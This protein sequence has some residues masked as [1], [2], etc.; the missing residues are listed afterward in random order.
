MKKKL[1]ARLAELKTRLEELD[2]KGD[3]ELT[4]EEVNEYASSVDEAKG[5][6]A[7]LK[8]LEG[9]DEVNDY[10]ENRGSFAFGHEINVEGPAA[11]AEP[12]RLGT[13]MQDIVT[14]VRGGRQLPRV[15]N[16]QKRV[17]EEVKAATGSSESVPSDGGFLV[18][19]EMSDEIVK[20]VYNNNELVSRASRRTISTGNNGIKINAVDETSRA[21]GSRHGGVRAYWVAEGD[22]STSSKPK[23]RQMEFDLKKLAVLY[24]AT[25]EVLQDATVLQQ[26][27][28]EAV[29]DEL[30]F[31][32]QDAI[33]NGDGSGKPLGILQ[34]PALVSQ[35]KESG[36]AANTIQYENIVKMYARAWGSDFIW[37]GN[38]EIFP[39]LATMSLAVGTGGAP[40][41]M[42]ANRA[43]GM[44]YQTLMGYPLIFVEQAAAL[45]TV[46]DLILADMSQYRLVDKGGVQSAMSI[47]V[48][49]VADEIVFRWLT[50]VDG[51]PLWNSALTPYKG[52]NTR[53]P[54]VALA[55]RS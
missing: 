40:V 35:A 30:N 52:S 12:Y 31:K 25:D 51:Q 44:P 3:D 6:V 26:E 37:I 21:D 18:G 32:L 7:K 8:Q 22:D 46:G 27:V 10:V 48:E 24:Y 45:G 41:W 28:E 29:T 16:Y 11:E 19:K 15:A 20:R 4:E 54:F 43:A 1:Q 55:T 39:Q 2:A 17:I 53:S 33:V 34:A 38:Q 42:P 5:I 23:F 50:R 36:Q 9:Q 49:F 47:H 14:Q 13:Y